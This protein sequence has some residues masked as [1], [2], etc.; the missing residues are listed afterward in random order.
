MGIPPEDRKIFGHHVDVMLG[1]LDPTSGITPEDQTA[2]MMAIFEQGNQLAQ[3]HKEN[4]QDN[5]IAKL[6]DGT[7]DGEGLSEMEFVTFFLLLI[8]GGIETTRTSTSHGMRLLMENPEQYQLLVDNPD[9]VPGAIEE[10]LRFNPA[11]IHMRR[12]AMEDVELGGMQI[13]KGDKVVLMYDSVNHDEEVFGDDS[14]IFD[15]T[16]AQRMPDLRNEH[17]TFGVGQHFCLGSHL[18]RKEMTIVFTEIVKRIRNPKFAGP[19]KLLQSNFMSGIPEMPI[20]F[21]MAS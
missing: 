19:P 15:V 12:T 17:R 21:D 20:T 18:A 14:E 8:V 6:I 16:R 2:S 4:P 5:L 11:F 3:Q 10:I 9:M 1:G 13:K 7:V